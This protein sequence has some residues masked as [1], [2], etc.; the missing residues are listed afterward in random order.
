M[1]WF[2]KKK[3]VRAPSKEPERTPG[4][5]STHR[6]NYSITISSVTTYQKGKGGPVTTKTMACQCGVTKTSST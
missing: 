2:G 3:E 4:G 5:T 6:H 1:G